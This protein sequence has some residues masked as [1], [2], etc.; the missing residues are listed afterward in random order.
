MVRWARLGVEEIWATKAPRTMARQL[1]TK[2]SRQLVDFETLKE[3]V[4]RV[5][6]VMAFSGSASGVRKP[7]VRMEA[8]ARRM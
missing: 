5:W 7:L 3:M 4:F 2:A 8:V 6:V 1:T